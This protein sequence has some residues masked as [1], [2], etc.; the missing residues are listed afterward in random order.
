MN[1]QKIEFWPGEGTFPNVYYLYSIRYR[2]R[3]WV[4]FEDGDEYENICEQI[5]AEKK[6][7]PPRSAA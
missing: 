1:F 5:L 2:G 4:E 3:F 6:I 7:I